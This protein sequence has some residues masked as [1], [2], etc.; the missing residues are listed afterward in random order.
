MRSSTPRPRERRAR[1]DTGPIDPVPA[2][3]PESAAAPG[4]ATGP[5]PPRPSAPPRRPRPSINGVALTDLY[6][7][8]AG[9][10]AET[11]G[12]SQA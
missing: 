5:R 11:K 7:I 6:Q 12:Q 1:E 2:A 8:Q 4:G 3:A 10:I 9:K